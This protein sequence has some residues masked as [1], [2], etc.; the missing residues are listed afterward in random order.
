MATQA[1]T[2]SDLKKMEKQLKEIQKFISDI[3]NMG[4]EVPAG[5][6]KSLKLLQ[7]AINTGSD[8][9]TAAQE[10]SNALK[11]YEKDLMSAC[12]TVEREMQAV[13][14]AGIARKWQARSVKFTLDPKNKDSVTARFIQKTVKR[15]T[16][17]LICKHWDYC[18]KIDKKMAA[19]LPKKGNKVKL[20]KDLKVKGNSHVKPISKIIPVK[21]D[22]G[23]DGVV[24]AVDKEFVSVALHWYEP[25]DLSLKV[26]KVIWGEYFK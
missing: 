7:I 24:F 3:E 13:C 10:A 19:L 18:A 4:G 17:A 15:Y 22:K 26:A 21:L 5:L 14:E 23:S 25:Q 20:I 12:K 9:G 1:L 11:A 2:D 6:K 8:I 16:P